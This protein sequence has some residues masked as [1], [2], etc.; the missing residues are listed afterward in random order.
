[1]TATGH[2]VVGKLAGGLYVVIKEVLKSNAALEGS[3]GK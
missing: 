2:Y 1:M 3:A